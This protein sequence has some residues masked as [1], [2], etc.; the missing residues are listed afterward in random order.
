MEIAGTLPGPSG[1]GHL[2]HRK[3]YRVK[4]GSSYQ[5][6]SLRETHVKRAVCD[7]TVVLR[8]GVQTVFMTFRRKT[9]SSISGPPH[10]LNPVGSLWTRLKDRVG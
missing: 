7:R 2:Y 6:W 5:N 8:R 10:L 4:D 3:A 9:S 1:S